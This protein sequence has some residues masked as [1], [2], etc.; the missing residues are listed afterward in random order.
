MA[1]SRAAWF[2]LI[3]VVLLAGCAGGAPTDSAYASI[4]GG[5]TLAPHETRNIQIRSSNRGNGIRLCNNSGSAG[6]LDATIGNRNPIVLQPG[7]CTRD[8]GDRIALS[9]ASAGTVS[10]NFRSLAEPGRIR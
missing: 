7:E 6:P 3:A 2:G 5:F 1:G 8:Y 10:G 4:F 9:N